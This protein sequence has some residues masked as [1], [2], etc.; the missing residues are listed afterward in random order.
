MLDY[1]D[2]NETAVPD[3]AIDTAW[4]RKTALSFEKKISRNAEMR[5]KYD[6]Q[7]EKFMASEADLDAEV[8]GLSVLSEH[9]ELFEE[10]VRLGCVRSLVGLLSHENTDVAI[11]VVGLLGELTDEEVGEREWGVLVRELVREDVVG[12][13]VQNLGRLDEE[14]EEDREG[15]YHVLEVLEN[16]LSD[17]KNLAGQ[18]ELVEWLRGRIKRRIGSKRVTQNQQ[19]AAETLAMLMQ[20]T[21]A[22]NQETFVEMDGI[23]TLLELLSFYRKVD[24]E[25]DSDE[26]EWVENLFDCLVC[27]VDFTP[28][29][30]KFLIGE[31]V[32]LCLIMLREGKMSKLR[33]LRILDHAMSGEAAEVVC[34]K[35]IEAAG[36]KT[37]FGMFMKKQDKETTEHLIGI[38]ASLLRYQP[39]NSSGRIRTLA[40]FVEKDYEKITKLVQLKKEYAE[41]VRV[42]NDSINQE[43]KALDKNEQDDMADE[44]LSRQLDVGLFPLQTLDVILSWLVAEDDGARKKIIESLGSLD[45]LSTSL[46][47]QLDGIEIGPENS[48][49]AVSGKEMLEALLR[50]L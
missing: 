9:P 45:S 11:G 5:A 36:L 38:F 21:G 41:K 42:V 3:E 20:I 10:F 23:D 8:K 19:Y 32:E 13:L 30:T 24:P 43:R 31:G 25:K 39:A 1:L 35:F 48:P 34:E 47:E 33:A 49:T 40:K 7:P 37:I 16:L 15:V 18:R 28:G 4:L 12:L 26:E 22:E 6:G 50:C 2:A 17:G 29:A 46:K 27:L 44:W 14:R